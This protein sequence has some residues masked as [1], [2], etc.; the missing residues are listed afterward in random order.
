MK[1]GNLKYFHLFITGIQNVMSI[2]QINSI[3]DLLQKK[4]FHRLL[5]IHNIVQSG[6]YK[7]IRQRIY[8]Q[9][10]NLRNILELGMNVEKIHNSIG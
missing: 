4:H 1:T 9:S 6:N 7:Q 3:D 8:D 2:D 5:R 10:H